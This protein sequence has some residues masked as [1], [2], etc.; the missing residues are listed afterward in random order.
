MTEAKNHDQYAFSPVNT[1]SARLIRPLY[2]QCTEK[3]AGNDKKRKDAGNQM[4]CP[5]RNFSQAIITG[6]TFDNLEAY[7]RPLALPCM[8]AN[9]LPIFTTAAL[10]V[11]IGRCEKAFDALR[12]KGRNICK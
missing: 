10:S 7:D 2:G 1:L 6:I 5:Y 8:E 12:I 11:L 3:E 4:L 9:L